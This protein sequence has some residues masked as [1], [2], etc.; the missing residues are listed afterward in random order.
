M[1]VQWSRI[2]TET[3]SFGAAATL[4]AGHI[5]WCAAVG[6]RRWRR[7][8]TQIASVISGAYSM[9]RSAVWRDAS[10][11]G[12][13]SLASVHTHILVFFFPLNV[14][15]SFFW[16]T[17]DNVVAIKCHLSDNNDNRQE[18]DLRL[19]L[20]LLLIIGKKCIVFI[21]GIWSYNCV[22]VLI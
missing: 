8:L 1:N 16:M 22:F 11:Q 3:D 2:P 5:G 21:F 13:P 20:Q 12:R 18:S 4:S 15:F 7:A 6:R 10:R 14:G 9:W 17:N 19:K